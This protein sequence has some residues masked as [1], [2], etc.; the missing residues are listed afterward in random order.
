MRKILLA[1]L[2]LVS[3]VVYGQEPGYT[4]N[5][6]Q[7][8]M[9]G[10]MIDS[11][12]DVPK[13]NGTPSGLRGGASPKDGKVA[14]DTT[15][16][17]M[18]M[19][20]GGAW[21]R[22][23]NYSEIGSV[24]PTLQ[25]V[26]DAG[27]TTTN[28]MTFDFTGTSGVLIFDDAG[29]PNIASFDGSNSSFL[30]PTSIGFSNGTHNKLIQPGSLSAS[31]NYT[32]PDL[33]GTFALTIATGGG[34]GQTTYTTGDILY[35]SATNTLSK[36]AATTNGYVLTLA[37]GVPT[38]AAASGGGTPG[39]SNTQVQWND[40]GSF[41]GISGAT[42]DGTNM[43]FGSGNLRATSPRITTGINDANGNELFLLTATSSAVNEITY[44]N[45]ATGNNPSFTASG[46]DSN[47]GF[48]FTTKGTG[49]FNI[50]G[51]S[52]QAGTLRL[53]EDTDD[54]TNYTAFKVGTQSG[55]I[56]YT[57]PTADGT[58]GYVL[59]TNG[60]GVL[61]WVANGSGGTPAG[62]FGNVQINR[63]SA[64]ATPA[65]DSLDF[66]SA[67]G[68]TVK[69][70][71][72][73]TSMFYTG[74]L[75]G[76]YSGYSGGKLGGSSTHAV[77]DFVDNGSRIGEFY[78]TSSSF[79]FFTDAG[80]ALEFYTN[81]SFTAPLIYGSGSAARVGINKFSPATTLDV[82]GD[83]QTSTNAYIAST[84]GG[85]GVG[86]ITISAKANI[87]STTEQLRLLYDASNYYSTT[88]SSTGGVTF[89]AVGSGAG[90]AFSDPVSSTRVIPV[91][92]FTTSASSL[93]P[94]FTAYRAYGY[95]ALAANLTINAPTGSPSNGETLDIYIKDDGTSR[96]LS[97]NAA[98]IET[99]ITLPASTTVGKAIIISI[100][101]YNSV[102]YAISVQEVNP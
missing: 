7:Y 16:G 32:L 24:V 39:G 62:N 46:D 75:T 97:W 99:G 40:A 15:N 20:T 51:N 98:Y 6:F 2:V 18:Y 54:G 94:D 70:Y 5:F 80:K 35:A 36:L 63:N 82:S 52:T 72:N 26:T 21:V 28:D 33:G 68:L 49:N 53:F 60:S 65:S 1:V 66:E 12:L 78:T 91:T 86:T 14:I 9:R 89:N 11:S 67:T 13:Y 31:Y 56:T 22:I 76:T 17:R 19:Y 59:S 90:F 57:L 4:P 42:S 58:S 81:N 10:I 45:A 3:A 95:T 43:T 88:V 102:Y 85:L 93:T 27:S 38:W 84:S 47:I 69:G 55:D 83:F 30:Q 48:N 25:Q 29:N 61:S 92:S 8:K 100:V 87:L 73:A 44:A 23:A 41:N 34:T 77:L 79:L 64:F 71:I 74:G 96:T 37:G 50:R 101:Y